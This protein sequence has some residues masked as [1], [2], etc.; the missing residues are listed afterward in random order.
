MTDVLCETLN[1]TLQFTKYSVVSFSVN[2]KIPSHA[3]KKSCEIF[4]A[5]LN[6]VTCK[7]RVMYSSLQDG[8]T[9]GVRPVNISYGRHPTSEEE[10]LSSPNFAIMKVR[11]AR[12]RRPLNL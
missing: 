11:I 7:P 1:N 8:L 6:I 3:S 9:A 10:L 4:Q 2:S 12:A 5:K